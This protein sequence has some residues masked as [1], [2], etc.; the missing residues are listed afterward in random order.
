MLRLGHRESYD[1]D[2]FISDAQ[3]L[4]F[5][6]LEKNDFEFDIR[7]NDWRGD[8]ARFIKPAFEGIGEIDFIVAG[9]LTS[10]PS[11]EAN[12]DGEKY[13]VGDDS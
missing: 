4:H 7:P 5:F 13:S 3:L 10:S 11:T 6:D 12:V 8:G 9:E 2:I 1:I